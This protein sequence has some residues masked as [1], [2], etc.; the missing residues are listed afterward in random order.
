V[1]FLRWPLPA[2][3][4]AYGTIDGTRLWQDVKQHA[5]IAERY[6]QQGH[7]QFWGIIAGTAGDADEAQWLL[8]RYK[9]IGLADTHVQT[10]A[11]FHPQWAPESWE[12]AVTGD[13]QPTPLT[14]ALPAYATTSTNGKPLDLLAVY[15]GLGSD[16]D[17]AGRD[18]RGKAVLLF[19]EGTSYSLGPPALLKRLES[20]V[21]QRFVPSFRGSS[22]SPTSGRVRSALPAAER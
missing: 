17:L 2:A 13:R 12:V 19:R 5:D 11:L 7:P 22:F 8:G 10:V 1:E 6:R 4:R 14:S 3:A 9:Q 15:V 16:A 21:D 18:V 20:A